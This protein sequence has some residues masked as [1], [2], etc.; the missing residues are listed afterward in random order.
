MKIKVL[1][2]TDYKVMP[3]KNGKGSTTEIAIFP[4]GSSLAANDFHWRL[5]TAEVR[6]DGAFSEFPGCDR[7]LALL[8][9]E[10]MNLQFKDHDLSV[11]P[12]NF[13]QFSG[14]KSVHGHLP[15]GPIKDL[16][17]IYKTDLLQPK[18]HLLTSSVERLEVSTKNALVFVHRGEV[19]VFLNS[20]RL[21]DVKMFQSV[22]LHS[23]PDNYSLRSSP[24]SRFFLIELK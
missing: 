2:E 17:F 7:Y 14:E 21:G 10:Q 4:E 20:Q 12:Q 8:E 15:K 13:L 19:E 6:E 22:C 18:F 1:S 24:G 16:N 11:S 5:S 23:S 3:W 9:G